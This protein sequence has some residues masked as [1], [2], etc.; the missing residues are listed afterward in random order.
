VAQPKG[1]DGVAS[2]EIK[3][4]GDN[5][6]QIRYNNFHPWVPVIQCRDPDRYRWGKAGRDYRGL[7]KT[8]IAD[9][10]TRKSHTQI[11]PA[12]VVQTLIPEL[13]LGTPPVVEK[14]DAGPATAA[15]PEKPKAGCGCRA[16]G[17]SAGDISALS[18]ALALLGGVL[19]RRLRRK[20]R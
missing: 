16:A 20:R 11:K 4:G 9:D 1:K 19:G 15:L 7:R 12:A 17:S 13:G 14:A 8:W 18:G 5:K 2:T 6:L 3:T 10:L